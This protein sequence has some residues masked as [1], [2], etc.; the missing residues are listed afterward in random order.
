MSV[1]VGAFGVSQNE[2]RTREKPKA[3]LSKTDRQQLVMLSDV[4][5][6]VAYL[7][8]LGVWIW[9]AAAL[10]ESGFQGQVH[11][12]MSKS[13]ASSIYHLVVVLWLLLALYIGG[14]WM[15]LGVLFGLGWIIFLARVHQ[16]TFVAWILKD[17]TSWMGGSRFKRFLSIVICILVALAFIAAG[18]FITMI[19][20]GLF[21]GLGRKIAGPPPVPV[22]K[23][24]PKTAHISLPARPDAAH[25]PEANSSATIEEREAQ[26]PRVRR[27]KSLHFPL[28]D[29]DHDTRSRRLSLTL[30]ANLPRAG[31]TTEEEDERVAKRDKQ[32]KVSEPAAEEALDRLYWQPD[33]HPQLR[34]MLSIG[35]AL[36]NL[37][38]AA[39]Y[40][41]YKYE[42]EGTYRATWTEQIG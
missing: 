24:K 31:E 18:V 19:I 40:Y 10:F 3:M 5:Y 21:V 4:L 30:E 2:K 38:L 7:V 20:N 29:F 39:L 8:Q 22:K 27:T 14:K 1:V 42:R 36:T 6:S 25:L 23:D 17:Y 13:A 33:E 15:R 32:G 41:G 12:P 26:I 9:I 11:Q 37:V 35:F 28:T 16:S 34:R